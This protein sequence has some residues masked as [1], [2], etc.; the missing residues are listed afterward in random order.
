M[1]SASGSVTRGVTRYRPWDFDPPPACA[2]RTRLVRALYVGLVV[3]A[4]GAAVGFP[5]RGARPA[6][7]SDSGGRAQLEQLGGGWICTHYQEETAT[8]AL[9]IP[10]EGGRGYGN[11]G[12]VICG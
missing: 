12:G 4:P 8:L 6:S 9:A 10:G 11:D 7:R 2:G 3:R 1:T 5:A